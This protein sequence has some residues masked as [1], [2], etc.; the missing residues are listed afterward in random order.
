MKIARS[1]VSC[2]VFLTALIFLTSNAA[3]AAEES[4]LSAEK[5]K[6]LLATLQSDA[7]GAEKAL[8]CKLLAIHGSNAAVPELAKLLSNEQLASW[9]RIAL[10]AIPGAAADDALHSA[11]G[12]LK[13][14]LLTGVINS[15]G[16]RRAAVAVDR[17]N[18]LLQDADPEVA[19]AA[20]IAL[21]LIGNPAAVSSLRGALPKAS[22]AVRSAIAEACVV[23]AERA[24]NQGQSA[25]AIAIYDEVRNAEVP[26]QRILEATRGAILARKQAGLPLLTEQLQS[27]DRSFFRIGLSTARELPGREVD[28]ALAAE[29]GKASPDRAALIIQAMADRK[30]TV[31]LPAIVA[32]ATSGPDL[33]RLAAIV[34]LGR[35]GNTSCLPT[36]LDIALEPKV[37]LKAAAIAAMAEM[38]D[39]DVNQEIV[40][41]LNKADGKSYPLLIELVGKRRIEASD[42]LLKALKSRDRSVRSAALLAL[43]ETVPSTSLKVLISAAIT[44][45]FPEDSSVAQQALMAACVRMPD[46][47][48]CAAELASAL[49]K[50]STVTKT[51]LLPILSAVG[52]ANALAAIAQ[53]A[54][55]TEPQLQDLSSRLLG[56][57]MTADAA[58]VLLDLAKTAPGEKYQVRALRGYIRIARQFIMSEAE[59][60]EMCQKAMEASRQVQEQKMVL[61]VLRRYP[62]MSSLKMAMKATEVAELKDDAT[63]ATLTIAQKIG[64]KSVEVADLLKKV[65]LEKVKLEIVKAEFGAGTTQK[66]VTAV[67]QKQA[68]DLPVITLPAASYNASFGGDPLPGAV[69]QLKIQYKINGKAA[70]VTL[71][72]DALIVLPMP[73]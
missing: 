65:A 4:A 67:L 56:E 20:A 47:E 58:P 31:L 26:K 25:D 34:A 29:V 21:G 12:A 9:S 46:R 11:A 53:A 64:G 22:G 57:W 17:L 1:I 38:N 5:E 14:R 52:G 54:K 62:S 23:C 36:L 45:E 7:P 40:C 19:S 60:S 43:G 63:Q 59:R 37:E 32:A 44:P 33:V 50:S 35:V 66:D 10:E 8:A 51:A 15:L 70:E 30:E 24:L 28:E 3:W 48:A 72:E 39:G 16:V 55:S 18:T 42:V 2:V 61:D 68:G 73:K 41:L 13:G 6:G 27:A 69:K 49:E 71:A